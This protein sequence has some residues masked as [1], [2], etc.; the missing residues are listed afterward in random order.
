MIEMG[1]LELVN[2]IYWMRG[3]PD[4]PLNFFSNWNKGSWYYTTTSLG[5]LNAIVEE[6]NCLW[7]SI[8]IDKNVELIDGVG[9]NFSKISD[10]E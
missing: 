1:T 8:I 7:D 2:E 3:R 5:R 4:F 6:I 10:A 9:W